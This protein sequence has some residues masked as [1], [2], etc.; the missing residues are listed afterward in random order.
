VNGGPAG[1]AAPLTW[2]AAAYVRLARDIGDRALVDRPRATFD[3]YVA[4]TQG[5]T[6]LTVNAPADQSAVAASP[7][8]RSS[9]HAG[10]DFERL[11]AARLARL[12][13]AA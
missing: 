1:S 6:A 9:Y 7:L 2:S 13:P 10:E 5:T 8:T 3:R 12:A 4:H 11:R